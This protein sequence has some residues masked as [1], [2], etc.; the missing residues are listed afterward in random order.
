[1]NLL[2]SEFFKDSVDV[3]IAHHTTA[4]HKI[5][6]VVL[7]AV[8]VA[9]CS[10]PFVYVDVSVQDNGV[11]RPV[12]ERTEITVSVTEFV[13]SVYVKEGQKIKQRDT[14]LMFRSSVPNYKIDYQRKRLIDFD[15][16]LNDL[17]YLVKGQTPNSFKSKTRQQEYSL[18]IKQ[19]NEYQTTLLKTEKDFERNQKLYEKNVIA[20]EE[21]EKYKYDYEKAQIELSTLQESQI[22]RWQN[23]LNTYSNSCEEMKAA[24]KQELKNRDL[25]TLTSPISGTLDHFN[26]IYKGSNIQAGSRVAVIS[27]DSTICVEIYVSP[28]NI[29]YI[30]VGMPVNIQVNSFNYNEWGIIRGQVMEISSDFM[31][32]SGDNAYFYKVKCSLENNYLVRKNGVKGTLKKG[33]TVSAHFIITKRS[34]FDLLYQKMDDWINPTQ[35]NVN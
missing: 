30:S 29:G 22:S 11:V 24:M 2:P 19:K 7:M 6:W 34:L 15:E 8:A 18:F 35:Y 20:S 5:Y 33:M 3:Y 23:E 13:D 12:V 10:L 27:P 32:N 31:T 4:S 17:R 26:G 9:L 25:Y 1:M 28:R 16:H 21:Y 14:I